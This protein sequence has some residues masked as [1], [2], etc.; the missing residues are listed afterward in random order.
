MVVLFLDGC[1]CGGLVLGY[2]VCVSDCC[3]V[4]L[5]FDLNYRCGASGFGV[6]FVLVD[7]VGWFCFWCCAI[8]VLM[9]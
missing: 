2:L 8:V 9:F 4:A 7:M 3:V 5:V 6:L 1:W